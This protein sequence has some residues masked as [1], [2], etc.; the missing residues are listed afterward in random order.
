VKAL[1]RPG[2]I[3]PRALIFAICI[4]LAGITWIVFGQTLGYPFL[5]FDDPEYVY[6]NPHINGGLTTGGVIWAFTHVPA[7]DWYPLTT[8]SHMV[9]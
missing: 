7:P 8:I 4:F 9:D 2:S 6:E 5:N 1:L 3:A